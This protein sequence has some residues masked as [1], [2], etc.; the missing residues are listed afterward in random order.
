MIAV[1]HRASRAN[2][3]VH[4]V[5][6]G[7]GTAPVVSRHVSAA[8]RPG[9]AIVT[10]PAR[11]A[12]NAGTDG[13]ARVQNRNPWAHVALRTVAPDEV[14]IPERTSFSVNLLRWWRNT[15]FLTMSALLAIDTRQ[16]TVVSP[17]RRND[18]AWFEHKLK[19]RGGGIDFLIDTARGPN[20]P[21]WHRENNL[22]FLQQAGLVTIVG[23]A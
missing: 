16:R 15:G 21:D 7:S 5:L 20:H 14:R 22:A 1:N 12:T 19:F 9:V 17:D 2:T 3:S 18:Y 23:S 10:I 4:G 11:I 13:T 8:L 6:S